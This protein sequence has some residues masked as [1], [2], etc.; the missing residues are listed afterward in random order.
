MLVFHV[1]TTVT[2]NNNK[3]RDVLLLYKQK[4]DPDQDQKFP[5]IVSR[6]ITDSNY[7]SKG[8]IRQNFRPTKT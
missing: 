8:V 1:L 7:C 4:L 5:S 2:I 3:D 6:I